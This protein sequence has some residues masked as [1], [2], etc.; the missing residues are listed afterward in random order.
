L[1]QLCKE[2]NDNF[3]RKNYLSSAILGRAIIDHIPPIFG[4]KKFDEVASQ[5]GGQSFKKN[6][7]HLNVSMRS[8]SDRNL[9]ETIS[10]KEVLPNETQINFS[11][12]LDV[13]LAEIV[14]KLG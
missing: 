5:Y 7:A 11:Q 1:I 2:L 14:K 6:V 8:I 10:K 13:L 9:H 3:S 12:D 4:F